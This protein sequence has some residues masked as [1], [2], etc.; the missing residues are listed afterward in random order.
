MDY[1]TLFTTAFLVGLSGA[2]MPGPMLTVTISETPRRGFLVG[3]QIVFGHGIVEFLLVA[4]LAGGLSYYIQQPIVTGGIGL[5]GGVVLLWFGWGIYK[6]TKSGDV[7]LDFAE[8]ETSSAGETNRPSIHPWILGI[9]LSLTNPY[10]FLWWAT[11]GVSYV[12]VAMSSGTTGLVTFFTGH[13]LSDLAWFSFVS[14]IVHT[15]RSFISGRVYRGV[16]I[17]CA[18]FLVLL[19]CWFAYDGFHK[20][21]MLV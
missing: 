16:L 14:F 12:V 3:P 19:G 11:V 1:F 21:T 2:I 7:C 15:G 20:L 4:C 9:I 13:I 5:I 8:A 18:A 6:N 17:F 10:W